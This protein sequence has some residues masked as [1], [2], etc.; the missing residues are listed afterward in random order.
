[1]NHD[2]AV[3]QGVALA[4]PTGREEDRCHRRR[5]TEADRADRRPEVLHRV[6]DREPGR[7][8]AAGR[9]D[10]QADVLLGIFRL[11]EQQLGDDEV[12]Q[13]VLDDV[14]DEDDPL[15]QQPRVDVVGA[16]AAAGGFDDHG[17]EHE[18]GLP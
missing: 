3:R 13:V 11:E 9:V 2:P 16:L 7:H 18:S 4:L 12:R 17:H 14:A 5:L 1:V 8:D 15:L 6:V 10:V